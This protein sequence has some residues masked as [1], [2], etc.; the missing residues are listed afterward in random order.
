MKTSEHECKNRCSCFSCMIA[1]NLVPT[2]RPPFVQINKS[3]PPVFNSVQKASALSARCRK[4]RERAG[5]ISWDGREGSNKI[6]AFIENIVK[7]VD[8]STRASRD[9]T[10][11]EL[12][13]LRL[14]NFGKMPKKAK[15]GATEKSKQRYIAAT[16][17]AAGVSS[18]TGTR[19]EE[20]DEVEETQQEA[21][22]AQREVGDNNEKTPRAKT[23]KTQP[24]TDNEDGKTQQVQARAARTEAD[25]QIAQAQNLNEGQQEPKPLERQR[26][27]EPA[28]GGWQ[29]NYLLDYDSLY[30]GSDLDD[31]FVED[32]LAREERR[33]GR[34]LRR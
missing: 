3:D 21:R 25:N 10:E 24:E 28:N 5:A 32:P 11:D 26:Q 34:Y 18:K 1:A 23:G 27:Q 6:K 14:E 2:C 12:G 16:M 8:N 33:G 31:E 30:Y 7:P 17:K 22:V 19:Q 9:L 4:F 29:V 15:T 13:A 20:D